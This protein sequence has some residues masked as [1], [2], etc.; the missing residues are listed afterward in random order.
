MIRACDWPKGL[1]SN[2][3]GVRPNSIS[4]N[5]VHNAA[6]GNKTKFNRVKKKLSPEEFADMK[7]KSRCRKCHEIGYWASDH[8]SNGNPPVT[9]KG[10]RNEAV[11]G[12][13]SD[14]N[15]STVTFNIVNFGDKF[16]PACL[17]GPLLDDGCPVLWNGF[18]EEFKMMV[19][20]ILSTW[21]GVLDPLP[22]SIVERPNWQYGSGPSH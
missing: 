19:P 5:A 8:D 12:T 1:D 9:D 21:D 14:K 17:K 10:G 22:D 15:K 13:K 3:E 2:S 20:Q 18:I 11:Q 16:N 7:S 6:P 4:G